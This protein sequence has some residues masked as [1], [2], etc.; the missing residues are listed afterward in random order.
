MQLESP[1]LIQGLIEGH[2]SV[3]RQPSSRLKFNRVSCLVPRRRFSAGKKGARG[4]VG[5][6]QNAKRVDQ[7]QCTYPT[8]PR[9]PSYHKEGRRGTR[10][11]STLK[12]VF[13]YCQA[14]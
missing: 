7:K 14:F 6:M 8:T 1:E 11:P 12:K 5:R 2:N 13:F 4:V 9:A 3:S 10:Q